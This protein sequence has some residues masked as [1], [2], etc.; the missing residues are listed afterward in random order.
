MNHRHRTILHA[1]FAHPVSANV[2]MRGVEAV[3]KELGAEVEHGH[4][5]RMHV[6][7]AGRTHGFPYHGHDLGPDEV[8]EMKKFL[9]DCGIDPVTQYPI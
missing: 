5:G 8:R 7:L 1:L 4:N 9:I 2:P 3:L 6:K